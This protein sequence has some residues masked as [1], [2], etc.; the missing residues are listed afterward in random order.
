VAV[1]RPEGVTMLRLNDSTRVLA[2]AAAVAGMI[3]ASA[4][5][6]RA[7]AGEKVTGEV[8]DLSCYLAHPQTSTG[9]SHRKCAETCA[10]KGLPMGI[11]TDD[12]QV[13]VLLE[14]HEKP[15]GYAKA[16]QGA[17][18]T[19]TVEGTKVTQGGMNGIVVESVK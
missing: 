3:F 2:R 6:R 10:K 15:D 1:E 16:I 7:A 9:P 17:A 8:I 5:A 13:Y 19:V 11:L 4:L 14:D 12:K 18:T